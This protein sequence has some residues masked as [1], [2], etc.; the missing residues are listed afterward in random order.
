MFYCKYY[1]T[2]PERTQ[3]WVASL[4][5]FL[6]VKFIYFRVTLPLFKIKANL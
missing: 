3:Q 4:Q 1:L 2:V 5:T 6:H